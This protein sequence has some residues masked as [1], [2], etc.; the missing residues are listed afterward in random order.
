MTNE[1]TVKRL[2]ELIDEIK[3]STVPKPT[4]P[5]WTL[6]KVYDGVYQV[7]FRGVIRT[8]G[9]PMSLAVT[10]VNALNSSKAM[11]AVCEGVLFDNSGRTCPRVTQATEA[12][13]LEL[14]DDKGRLK[15]E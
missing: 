6:A 11:K 14:N 9:L 15:D 4:E 7:R 10:M 1:E 12:L 2:Q 5:E 13:R 8:L 3:K